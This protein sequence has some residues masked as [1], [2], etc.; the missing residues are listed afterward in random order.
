MRLPL[1]RTLTAA[2]CLAFGST[3]L[4]LPG[5]IKTE[6]PRLYAT[7]GDLELLA[8]RLPAGPLPPKK[9]TLRFKIKPALKAAGDPV[10]GVLFGSGGPGDTLRVRHLDSSDAAAGQREVVL[11]VSFSKAGSTSYYAHTAIRLQ[12][13]VE[14]TVAISYDTVLKKV[15]ITSSGTVN[16]IGYNHGAFNWIPGNQDFLATARKG[17][18]VT[19]MTMTDDATGQVAWSRPVVDYELGR[20]RTAL[21]EY[22]TGM[23]TTIANCAVTPNPPVNAESI[24]DVATAGRNKILDTAR[25]LALASRLKTDPAYATAA[26]RYVDMIL[27]IKDHQPWGLA[28]GTEWSMNARIGA[29]GVLYDWFYNE[30]GEAKRTA[31]R[32]AIVQTIRT[33]IPPWSG[34]GPAPSGY[35]NAS[36]DLIGMICGTAVGVTTAGTALD[37]KG[38]PDVARFYITGH[39]FSA[40]TGTALGLLAIAQDS[41]TKDNLN[42]LPM[43]DRIYTHLTAGVIPAR[44]YISGDGGHHALFAYGGAGEMIERMVMWQRAIAPAPGQQIAQAQFT[45]KVIRP[46]IYGLRKDGA[47]PASG[48][49]YEFNPGERALGYM[50]VAAATR[51]DAVASAFYQQQV[52]P[53]RGGSDLVWDALMFPG[54]HA[55]P[56]ATNTWPLSARYQVAGNVLMRDSWDYANA[57]LLDFKSTSFISENHHHLDQN[58]FSVFRHAPLLLDTGAYDAYNSTHWENYYRRTIAHNTV[59]VFDPKE[60]FYR[61]PTLLSNDG[62]QWI[63]PGVQHYPTLPEIRKGGTNHLDGITHYH[64]DKDG[65]YAFVTGNASK[66]YSAKLDQNEGFLRSIVYLRPENPGDRTSIVVFDRIRTA[67]TLAATSLLHTAAMPETAAIKGIGRADPGRIALAPTADNQPLLVRNGQGMMT[68]EPLLPRNARI[69]LAGGLNGDECPQVMQDEAQTEVPK[70]CRFTARY[71]TENDGYTWT[72]FGPNTKIDK[73]NRSDFGEWRIEIAAVPAGQ[74]AP[75]SHQYFLNVLH[76]EDNDP[77]ADPAANTSKLLDS[78]DNSAAAAEVSPGTLVVFAKSALPPDSLRWKAP[79]GWKGSVLVAGLKA[80]H[81]Y[82]RRYDT[83]KQE[84]VLTVL[85]AGTMP[86]STNSQG[87]LEFTLP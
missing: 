57:T 14:A 67:G 59:V 39:H 85:G 13:D 1:C 78:S 29:L 62:G 41:A 77:F 2:V 54:K 3:A 65:R 45:D 38:T 52:K 10:D 76:V 24:C 61:G 25:T 74:P 51:G 31:M 8:S 84:F 69:T 64:E 68:V 6:R 80:N 17:D 70:D 18:V 11:Q 81:A 72:N 75:S 21:L 56:A 12:P 73:K 23:A 36:F 79:Q 34:P 35:P 19:A 4:A 42:V 87:L 86:G 26:N 30:L 15:T 7:K 5:T 66:A 83:S 44:E 22:A 50:A 20:G 82:L 33:D 63:K 28:A 71:G 53:R 9:G 32:A 55:T 58:S 40:Q 37:C 27:A 47:F 16:P 49:N 48:D 60:T 46:Y 43:I